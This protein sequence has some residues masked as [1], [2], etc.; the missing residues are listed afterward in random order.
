MKNN[1]TW[2]HSTSVANTMGCNNIR[3]TTGTLDTDGRISGA[4]KTDAAFTRNL[5]RYDPVQQWSR[6]DS[7]ES[8]F[9]AFDNR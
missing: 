9:A 5:R 7:I 6:S 4:Q 1:G 3:M 8:A 2:S